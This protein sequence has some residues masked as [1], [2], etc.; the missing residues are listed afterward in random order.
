MCTVIAFSS[1]ESCDLKI[2]WSNSEETFFGLGI[3]LITFKVRCNPFRDL[4][5]NNETLASLFLSWQIIKEIYRSKELSFGLW[6]HR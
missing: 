2:Q 1:A 3:I 6:N 4:T 5:R